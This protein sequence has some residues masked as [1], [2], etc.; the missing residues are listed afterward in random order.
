MP[1]RLQPVYLGDD[2][3][4]V[5]NYADPDTGDPVDPDDVDGDGTPDANVTITGPDG[6]VVIDSVA[7]THNAT[8]EFEYVWD[9]AVDAAGDGQYTVEAA[10]DFGGETKHERVTQ[11][12][13]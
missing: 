6:T 8:G 3:P 1:P 13:Q 12:V 7:M 10:A 9:T 5:I 2:V 11:P 4:L